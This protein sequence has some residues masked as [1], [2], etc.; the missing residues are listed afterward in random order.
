[1]L[2]R[3]REPSS[4]AAIGLL[5]QAIFPNFGSEGVDVFV[6][7]ATGISA[8]IAFFMKEDNPRER[9]PEVKK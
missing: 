1:M 3:F 2:D 5:L 8:A 7:L 9:P 4:W 6:D